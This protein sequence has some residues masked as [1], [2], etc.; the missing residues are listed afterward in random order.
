MNE[1]FNIDVFDSFLD[2]IL[3]IID[4]LRQ[5]SDKK[6]K[7]EKNITYLKN[8]IEYLTCI[9]FKSFYLIVIRVK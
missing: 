2:F 8:K 9:A 3:Y 1:D 5:S 6:K 7:L 4:K